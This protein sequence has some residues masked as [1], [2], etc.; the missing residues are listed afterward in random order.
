MTQRVIAID[1]PNFIDL[2]ALPGPAN[3]QQIFGNDHPLALEIGSGTG[4]F[5]VELARRNPHF[6]YLAIDIY[7]RGCYKTCR[8]VDIH[9]LDNVRVA[10]TEARHLLSHH[11]QQDQLAAIYINCP[12]PWPKKRHR[13]RRLVQAEFLCH[14]RHYLMP[15]GSFYFCT[16]VADYA[17]QVAK[18]LPAIAGLENA[19]PVAV[20]EGIDGYPVS[21]YMR[22]FLDRGQRLYY[23]HYRK[24]HGFRDED[25]PLP[26]ITPCFRLHWDRAAND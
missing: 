5:V 7:N 22:R 3:W 20:A 8:K 9:G 12:D 26:E 6:N 15:T 10:R 13:K 4:D 19:L 2:D 24:A 18:A 21:K 16:D 17:E 11:M 14:L 23:L 1:S 25:H